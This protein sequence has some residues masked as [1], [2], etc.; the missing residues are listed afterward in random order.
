MNQP[1]NLFF[2]ERLQ[3]QAETALS[4]QNNG[5]LQQARDIYLKI[6]SE[7]PD[8]AS[9]SFNLGLSYYPDR[10]STGK[11]IFWFEQVLQYHPHHLKAR[12]LLAE[13]L[14]WN[15]EVE[16]SL[17]LILKTLP[18]TD[19]EFFQGWSQT[20]QRQLRNRQFMAESWLLK[21]IYS[22]GSF[23]DRDFLKAL[24]AWGQRWADPLTPTAEAGTFQL[25]ESGKPLRVGYFSQEFGGFSSGFLML[26]LLS[27]HNRQQFEFIAFADGNH[28][29]EQTQ[30]FRSYFHTWHDVHGLSPD[31]LVALIRSEEI[32]I[33]VDLA[34]HTHPEALLNFARKPAPVQITGLGFG[35][36]VAIQAMDG[37]ISDVQIFPTDLQ[38]YLPE[39]VFYLDSAI[40]WQTPPQPIALRVPASDVPF[41]FGSANGLY[42]LDLPCLKLWA[43][44]LKRCPEALLWLKAAPLA[45]ELS[46]KRLIR[47][48]SSL[49]VAPERLILQGITPPGQHFDQFYNGIDLALDPFPYNGGV[50]SC[51][52]L[53]MGVPVLSLNARNHCGASILTSLNMTEFLAASEQSYLE[54]A[55]RAYQQHM[56]DPTSSVSR[57]LSAKRQLRERL[58]ASPICQMENYARQVESAYLKLWQRY[59]TQRSAD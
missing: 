24:R 2:S 27:H 30:R 1:S 10:T 58:Q 22:L 44:I 38:D 50:T 33:L 52:A 34:G 37:F 15:G 36:P 23:D 47:F 54:K 56:A 32:A 42:K 29:A 48:F 28:S 19:P 12:M 31:A 40:H 16:A 41:V 59:L 7:R 5:Q 9:V 20:E 46:A 14:Y 53:W 45:C 55:C 35:T 3:K 17:R 6:L 51:D 43:E 13:S 25:P 21:C 49:G 26:P 8:F 4:L 57:N 11:A 39:S 18:E